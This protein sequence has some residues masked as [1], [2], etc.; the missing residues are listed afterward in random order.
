MDI[1]PNQQVVT[2]CGV[3]IADFGAAVNFTFL[4]LSAL[5]QDMSTGHVPMLMAYARLL[6]LIADQYNGNDLYEPKASP[7]AF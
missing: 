6:R 2:A 7:S 4:K 3:N 5:I 1:L